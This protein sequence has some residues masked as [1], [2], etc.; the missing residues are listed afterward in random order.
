ML[1]P[2]RKC[3]SAAHKQ[4]VLISASFE[5]AL[6]LREHLLEEVMNC[7]FVHKFEEFEEALIGIDKTYNSFEWK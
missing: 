4:Y 1:N 6:Q 3:E 7:S 5:F 2:L